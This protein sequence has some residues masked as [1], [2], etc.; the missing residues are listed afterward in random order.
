MLKAIDLPCAPMPVS[1][2]P[3]EESPGGTSG[4]RQHA[5]G[6]DLRPGP[7]LALNQTRAIQDSMGWCARFLRVFCCLTR[8]SRLRA[9]TSLPA[10]GATAL[11]AGTPSPAVRIADL[12]FS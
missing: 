1:A 7:R 11:L 8:S 2:Y 9:P 10:L 6:A 4:L 12:R 3:Q 5:A